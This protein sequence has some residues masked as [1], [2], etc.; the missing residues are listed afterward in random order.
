MIGPLKNRRDIAI[1]TLAFGLVCTG[2][3][4][5]SVWTDSQRGR[6]PNV[7]GPVFENWPERATNAHRIELSSSLDMFA[8]ERRDGR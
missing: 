3:G 4:V 8:L 2:F 5:G 1:L 7:E 6:A